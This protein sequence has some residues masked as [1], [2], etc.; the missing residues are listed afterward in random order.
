MSNEWVRPLWDAGVTVRTRIVEDAHPLV[1][2]E[3]A[4]ADEGASLFVLGT[5]GLSDAG[6]VR[7]GRL[8]L[9]LV[10]RTHL[11][12]VLVPPGDRS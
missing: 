4:A 12:V 6:G 8:P 5:R 11:A 3:G 9:Q 2:L 1:A 7:L 10:H